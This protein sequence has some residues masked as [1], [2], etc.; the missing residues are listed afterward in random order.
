MFWFLNSLNKTFLTFKN[1]K[2]LDSP[3]NLYFG[4]IREMEGRLKLSG[5]MFSFLFFVLFLRSFFSL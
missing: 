4:K 3:V 2:R 5:K 1:T